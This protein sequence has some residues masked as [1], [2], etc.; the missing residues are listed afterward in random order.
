MGKGVVGLLTPIL[1]IISSR[2]KGK[3]T[4]P[5]APPVAAMPVALPRFLLNQCPT[6][7]IEGVNERELAIPPITLNTTIH[8]QYSNHI[9]LAFPYSPIATSKDLIKLTITKSNDKNHNNVHSRSDQ[10]EPFRSIHIEY[11][12][13]V[14]PAEQ[15]KE[16]I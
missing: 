16:Y 8:C 7:A 12:T 6:A 15:C 10:E 9:K 14:D 13:D 11:G 5:K 1:G 4:P 3:I 2:S